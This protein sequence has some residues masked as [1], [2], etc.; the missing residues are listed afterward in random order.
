MALPSRLVSVRLNSDTFASR[1]G[2]SDKL[3]REV[4]TAMLLIR[5][6]GRMS[7]GGAEPV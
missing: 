5:R 4:G 1:A 7:A 3:Q 2:H 6:L